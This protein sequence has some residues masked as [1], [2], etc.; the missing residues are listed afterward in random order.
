MHILPSPFVH[1]NL[2]S[3]LVT[4]F[5]VFSFRLSHVTVLLFTHLSLEMPLFPHT[6]KHSSGAD[7]TGR[8][9][10]KDHTSFIHLPF[11]T[12]IFTMDEISSPLQRAFS[13]GSTEEWYNAI[14]LVS[15][16]TLSYSLSNS[17]FWQKIG[18]G[19]DQVFP[20]GDSNGV[21]GLLR[22]AEKIY[23]PN[24]DDVGRKNAGRIW[25]F[26]SKFVMLDRFAK[27][28][29]VADV[30]PGQPVPRKICSDIH[31]GTITKVSNILH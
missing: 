24:L 21:D 25:G 14:L 23:S 2:S 11:H 6:I 13:E 28:L 17:Y 12:N 5:F 19:L 31:L 15:N 30:Y 20:F 9:W 1:V 4:R 18:N 7:L 27:A 29:G 26:F 10:R 22:D 8:L 3:N 16:V